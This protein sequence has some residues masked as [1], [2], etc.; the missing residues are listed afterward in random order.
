[1]INLLPYETKRQLKAARTNM[2]LIRYLLTMLISVIFLGLLILGS[3]YILSESQKTAENSIIDV[4]T[5]N[6]SYSPSTSKVNDFNKDLRIAKQ[7]F[8]QQISYSVLL[9]ELAKTL[10]SGVILESPL[11]IDRSSINSPLMLKAYSKS[12]T[13]EELKTSFQN[14]TIFENYSLQ[15]L[16]SSSISRDYPYLITFSININKV[17]LK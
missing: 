14:N 8:E 7:I 11:V 10:P 9:S 13:D 12:S 4:Q 6:S 2:V 1:M 3:Y 17:R 16:N 5:G 15:S